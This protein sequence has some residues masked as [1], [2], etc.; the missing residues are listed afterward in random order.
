MDA[1]GTPTKSEPPYRRLGKYEVFGAFAQGGMASVH[2]ARIRGPSGFAK[3]VAVKEVN[4]AFA[5]SARHAKMLLA[6]AR[7][8]ARIRSPYA[9]PILDVV[10]EGDQLCIVMELVRGVSL[11]ELILAASARRTRIA[12]A[13]VSAM[14]SDALRGLHAAHEAT[15]ENGRPLQI[16]H[17][18]VSP[19]NLLVGADGMTR[20]LDFG[21]AKGL[22]SE[23][24]SQVGE[25][26]GKIGYMPPEQL[27]GHVT[28]QSDIYAAGVVLWEALVAA[29]LRKKAEKSAIAA[30][31]QTEAIAPSAAGAEVSVAVDDVVMTALSQD[32]KRR[33]GTAEAMAIALEEACPPASRDEVARLVEDLGFESLQKLDELTR[34]CESASVGDVVREA[35]AAPSA[36]A[37]AAATT[38][39]VRRSPPW[40]WPAV[41]V[42]ILAFIGSALVAKSQRAAP[43]RATESRPTES[44]PVVTALALPV[45]DADGAAPLPAPSSPMRSPMP[46]AAATTSSSAPPPATLPT[47]PPSKGVVRPAPVVKPSCSPPFEYDA[48]GRKRYKRECFP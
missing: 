13:I 29:R 14:L 5:A 7:L 43:P 11:N 8:G 19:Q 22:G 35:V 12:P 24:V 30:I 32:P 45:D 34:A 38:A 42:V 26:K 47:A 15:G 18:D 37:D 46:S 3:L 41:P 40:L 16:I 21:V 33:F 20:V 4:R 17:R 39:V 23:G 48:N 31:V 25:V 27:T 28:R 44:R 36:E 2:V 6:E 9:I 1:A 10:Q